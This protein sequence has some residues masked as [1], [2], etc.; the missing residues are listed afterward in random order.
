MRRILALS[1]IAALAVSGMLAAGAGTARASASAPAPECDSYNSQIFC[2]AF[3]P[4]SPVTWTETITQYGISY[5]STFP[6]VSIR[7]GC[8]VGARYSESYTYVSG[9]VT[10]SSPVASVLCNR[11]PPE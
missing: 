11:N 6:A 7:G 10:Y 5:T 1:S 3:A 8:S 9:G 2:D 4:V